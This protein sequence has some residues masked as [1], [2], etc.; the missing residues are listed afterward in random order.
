MPARTA[1]Q[2]ANCR[3]APER[4]SAIVV[5]TVMLLLARSGCSL[6]WLRCVNYRN[7]PVYINCYTVAPGTNSTTMKSGVQLLTVSS[8]YFCCKL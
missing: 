8:N 5:F 4:S 1:F 6:L 3:Q 2:W 7:P